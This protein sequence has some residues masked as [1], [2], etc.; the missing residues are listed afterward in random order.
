LRLDR[1][2]AAAPVCSPTRGSVLTGRHPNRFGCFSWGHP[3][4]PEEVTLAEALRG[5]GYATGHFGKWHLGALDAD[6]PVSPGAQGFDAWFSSPNFFE[7]SPLL[8]RNGKVEETRGEGSKVVV[9]AALDFIRRASEAQQPFLAVIWFGSPHL[10]H[11]ALDEDKQSYADQP[12][13]LQNYWGE[14]T[15]MD[16]AIGL[17]RSELKRLGVAE[18][19]LVW[20]TSDNG[21]TTPGSTGGLR[22]RK[23]SLWE[24]GLR[25]PA[26]IEWPARI[27]APRQSSVPCST[28]DIYPT[29]LALAGVEVANQP[30]LD[31]ISL[32]PLLDGPLERRSRPL[33]F[34]Q[35][36]GP[37][38]AVRSGDLLEAI[39]RGQRSAQADTDA[40]RLDPT[41]KY[42]DD[43]F[44]GHA[45]WLDE[46]WKL[47]RIA[48]AS[49]ATA[50]YELYDLATDPRETTDLAAQQPERVR[51]LSAQL[52]AWQQSVVRSLNRADY[53]VAAQASDR[54]PLFEGLGN[55][56]RRVTTA[57]AAAQ[58]YFDQGLSFLYAFNHDEAIRSFDQAAKLDP[59]CALAWWGIAVANGP[60]INNPAVPPERAAAAWTALAKAQAAAA[61]ASPVERQL[62]D[63][64]ARRYANPQPDDRRPLDEA[65]A[66][67]MRALFQ[68]HPD[69]TDIGALFAEAMMDLR[70][71][72]LWTP[73]GQPQPGTEEIV[74]T[75]EHVLAR[76]PNHP[77][78]LHLYIHAV[79]ASPHPEKADAAADRLRDLQPGLG[80]LV[81]MPSHIDVRRGRWA[82]AVVANRK[83]IDAD[84]RYREQS[85]KQGF[86]RI[87]MAHNH[88][89]LTYAAIMRGQSA[90]A[91]AEVQ[92]MVR[93]MPAE[94]IKDNAALADGFTAMPLEVLVRF[95]RWK[96]VLAAPEPPEHLPIAR[97]LRHVARGVA[98][99]STGKPHEARR[100]QA[101][102]LAARKTV[103]E[104]A[105]V[106]NNQADDILNVA[107]HLLAGEI[108]YR[109]GQVE[110]AL[111]ELRQAVRLED[112]LRYSE[113]PDWIH[114]VRH[115]LGATL[116]QEGRA[117]EAEGVY[118]ADLARQ[119]HNGWSLFGLARSLR[120]QDK[121]EEAQQIEAQ[122][123]DAWRDADVKI[124]SSC[125]CQP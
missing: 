70:P 97:T 76:Q 48:D 109:E 11:Q 28:V 94:W 41:L 52:A 80:H 36:P 90:L 61:K 54:V 77:L 40:Q 106:G 98:Y 122:F 21:A 92:E 116:L 9:D 4:R 102:F 89:M 105:V 110:P 101:S 68:K 72:D 50:R 19:T 18:N 112:L 5:A 113:P 108:L 29:V 45:A 60:H 111:D 24:G 39:R 38:I 64:L 114:P 32:V 79:E 83:A 33:G 49:G 13:A 30:P 115:A 121:P 73:E 119:P 71:W 10:P 23:A 55:F 124:T 6:S 8:A 34:W 58:R 84:R 51:E 99:A 69:D 107:Q 22:G 100:E 12:P 75:L 78:A 44:P 46:H 7:N 15:A 31:G 65:Y 37:G 103:P 53:R 27:K 2:Y 3:L 125:F 57:S 74:A 16:R 20:Y 104:G 120:L 1:F 87:Y 14:I 82:A 47:H 35:Y 66:A 17:L 67:A 85:P 86:Y 59:D 93:G 81:H 56:G 91:L 63:V 42:P 62:I 26:I 88:H 118:R 95:G 43:V 117:A 123:T 96:E 25:V